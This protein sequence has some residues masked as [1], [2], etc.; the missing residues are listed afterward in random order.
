MVAIVAHQL[1]ASP[2]DLEVVDGRVQVVGTPS[3][4]MTIAEIAA[5]AY[6]EP[7]SLPPG[8]PLGLEAQAR[9]SPDGVRDVVERLPHVRRARSTLRRAAS[10]SCATS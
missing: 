2:D 9:Y 10:R 3:K 5:K 6:T 8:L 1:E 7:A 4:G